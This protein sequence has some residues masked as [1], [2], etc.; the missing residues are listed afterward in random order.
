MLTY[1]KGGALL[2]MLE[3]YLGVERFRQGVS[4]YLRQHQYANTETNDLWDAI[5]ETSGEPV[6]RM[7]DSWIWQP[8]YPLVTASRR[9][10]RAGAAPAALRLR[11]RRRSTATPRRRRGSC[12]CTSASATTRSDACC[13]TADEA[14]VPLADPA[15]PSSST[16]AATASSASPTSDEL[17]GRG[18]AGEVLGS[19]DTLERYN[20]VDD[21]W[22]EVVAGR[23]A[24]RRL[25]AVRRG[26][27]RRARARGVAG[28]RA[29]P[30]RPRPPPRRRR[31]PRVPGPGRA[32]CWRRS[33]PTSASPSTARTTCA[34][35][36]AACSSPRWPS[37]ATTR[38]PRP[39]RAEL[40]DRSEADPGSVD[41][42]LVAAATSIVAAGGDEAVVRAHA[43]RLPRR[44]R[45]PRTSCATSTPSPSSTTRRSSCARA[46][47]P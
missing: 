5:E 3:Q 20:L 35:S 39:G 15:A 36:C 16:P 12:R 4:H 18:S 32:P 25:P 29:R 9:R 7:M 22:N 34:A 38:R 14:R 11:R 27:R 8:G 37:R 31:L 40:Y 43:R 23:L 2:R 10:R 19:L 33:S 26:L 6:R 46:S 44:P 47:W 28:D 13:S 24:G 30:A 21:A 42:E 45:R 1:Q 17:R 41:P